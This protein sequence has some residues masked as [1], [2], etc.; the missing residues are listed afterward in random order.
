MSDKRDFALI[1]DTNSARREK[2]VSLLEACDAECIVVDDLNGL[3]L[4]KQRD[5]PNNF[6]FIGGADSP[7][8]SNLINDLASD[9]SS[10]PP[11]L[12]GA[13]VSVNE[14]AS[15][16]STSNITS[17]DSRYFQQMIGI[18]K[19]MDDLKRLITKV[20]RTEVTVMISGESGTGKELCARAIHDLS[21]RSGSPFVPVNCGAIPDELLESELFGHEK[22]SFTGAISTR[23]GRFEMA[24]GGTLFLDEIGDMPLNMQVKLLRVLQDKTYERVG[25]NKSLKADVRVVTAT[26]KDLDQLVRLGKFREDLFYRL[27]VFPLM[28][29]ALRERRED[30][31]GLLESY[32]T[33]AESDLGKP[34]FSKAVMRSLEA[35][36]WPGNVRELVNLVDRLT[37]LFSGEQVELSDLPTQY[38]TISESYVALEKTHESKDG[39]ENS[40]KEYGRNTHHVSKTDKVQQQLDFPCLEDESIDIKEKIKEVEVA[41]LQS[42]LEQTSWVVA[43]AA[44]KLGLQRTTLVEKMKKYG[45]QKS[46]QSY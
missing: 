21:D 5:Q 43:K 10:L 8:L 11:A 22:G 39:A 35:Y 27:N 34:S 17:K 4:E 3:D 23:K 40:F 41:Y 9:K 24:Q 32:L 36:D 29:P 16:P 12:N 26:H 45:I 38:Q 13:S 7:P 6:V 42:A 28:V 37:V 19:S 1:V 31:S 46:S 33:K 30:I 14:A 15:P 25:G 2:I 44:K 20:A 18:S